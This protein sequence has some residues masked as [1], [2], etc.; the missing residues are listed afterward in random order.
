[1]LNTGTLCGVC[2]N[3]FLSQFTPK[4]IPSFS[5]L[6][7]A[8]NSTYRF[9]KAVE[10]MKA[11]MARRDI[12]FTSSYQNMMKHLFDQATLNGAQSTRLADK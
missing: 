9:D 7:D 6:T 10:T 1:M 3:I 11:M 2:S 12:P 5:W 8:G 4:H